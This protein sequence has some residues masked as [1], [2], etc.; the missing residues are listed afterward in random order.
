MEN[1]GGDPNDMSYRYKM[2]RIQTKIEGKGNGI[3]TVFPNIEPVCTALKR[4]PIYVIKYF[5]SELGALSKYDPKTKLGVVNGAHTFEAIH[6]ILLK[7]IQQFVL[8]THCGNPE[9]D[10]EVVGDKLVLTCRACGRQFHANP[11]HKLT[12]FIISEAQKS[13]TGKRHKK[14]KD[15]EEEEV[16]EEVA[17]EAE[18][19][20][21][22]EEERR[23]RERHERKKRHREQKEEGGEDEERRTH[24]KEHR[25]SKDEIKT[26]EGEKET[27][28]E[29]ANDEGDEGGKGEGEDEEERRRRHHDKEK[30]RRHKERKERKERSGSVSGTTEGEESGT[31]PTPSPSPTS[32]SFS[33]NE[34]LF[35]QANEIMQEMSRKSV[36][37]QLMM[38]EREREK[39]GIVG[40]NVGDEKEE[41]EEGE[42]ADKDEKSE[43][44]KEKEK[45]AKMLERARIGVS[46]R[47]PDHPMMAV[48][49]G[50]LNWE[51]N[52]DAVVKQG[53]AITAKSV[54]KV[55][56]KLKVREGEMGQLS[57]LVALERMMALEQKS[58]NKKQKDQQ[59]TDENEDM[60]W[61]HIL[62]CLYQKDL[63]DD[64]M[65]L[66]WHQNVPVSLRYGISEEDAQKTREK[67]T[68]FIDWLNGEDEEEQVEDQAEE[69]NDS[70]DIDDL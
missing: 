28:K 17:E 14:G 43:E 39:L 22:D 44:E 23:R 64:A 52:G 29:S 60:E 15:K 41:E 46:L 24:H 20:E 33:E 53:E 37:H 62:N 51:M 63:V 49:E 50:L 70:E 36:A 57:I 66:A 55:A 61:C 35:I 7:F 8:C 1:I 21:E 56:D 65:I 45:E 16:V 32:S 58:D 2:P 18:A 67:S 34:D 3:K 38:I 10:E 59:N 5:G 54:E 31:S 19:G 42:D 26:G 69:D 4:P 47:A 11:A 9:T 68:A 13:Q 30:K 40:W 25:H 6:T 48:V 27:D 12:N